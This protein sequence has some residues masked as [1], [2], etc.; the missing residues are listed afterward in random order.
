MHQT[1]NF[2]RKSGRPGPDG[3]TAISPYMYQFPEASKGSERILDGR[4]P[5]VYGSG[6]QI[7]S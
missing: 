3:Q 2:P 7:V 6:R 5:D 1:V 4:A